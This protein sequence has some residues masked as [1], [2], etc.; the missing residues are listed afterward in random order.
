VG[1]DRPEL[2][3]IQNPAARFRM[4]EDIFATGYIIRE[5]TWWERVEQ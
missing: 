3:R 5:E 2:R 1:T 4:D